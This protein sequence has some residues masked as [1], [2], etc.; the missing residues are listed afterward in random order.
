[1]T[2]ITG[3]DR[4]EALNEAADALA[5]AAAEADA[6]PVASRTGRGY[7]PGLGVPVEWSAT[8]RKQLTQV[9]ADRA[10]ADLTLPRR[11]GTAMYPCR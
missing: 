2:A 3:I 9:A 6:R 5:S 11:D 8:V 4:G 10:A 1:M 7:L